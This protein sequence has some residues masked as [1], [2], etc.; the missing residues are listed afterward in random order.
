MPGIHVKLSIDPGTIDIRI[1]AHAAR[2]TE[3]HL[4]RHPGADPVPLTGE[5]GGE[6]RGEPP[7]EPTGETGGKTGAK[8]GGEPAGERALMLP[9]EV[10]HLLSF[11]LA[12]V[13]EGRGLSVIPSRTELTSQRAA[14]MLNVS[15]P[16]LIGLLESGATPY[17]MVGQRRRVAAENLIEYTDRQRPEKRPPPMDAP[18]QP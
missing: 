8:P 7:R 2:R 16:H 10:A 6:S 4:G 9:R 3:D 11:I 13:A 14:D 5:P 15:R 18:K 1:T 17:R 12:Q